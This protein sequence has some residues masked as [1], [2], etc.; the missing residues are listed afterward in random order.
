MATSDNGGV[1]VGE[2]VSA[3]CCHGNY[4]LYPL[5]G[6]QDGSVNIWST[7]THQNLHNMK[8]HQARL[9]GLEV[10][11]GMVLSPY[12]VITNAMPGEL[13]AEAKKLELAQ[14]QYFYK[15]G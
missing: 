15:I 2:L 11:Y 3:F 10:H 14:A 7:K 12:S 9:S 4:V 8:A 6:H 1:D 13:Y 5:S